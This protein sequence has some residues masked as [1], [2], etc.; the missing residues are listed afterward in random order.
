MLDFTL[1]E[2][3]AGTLFREGDAAEEAGETARALRCFEEGAALGDAICWSR[4][5]L[6][7]D[8]GK[9]VQIDKARAMRCYRMAWRQRDTVA[10]L[11]IA[12]LYRERGDRRAMFRWYRRAAR[13]DDG[14][15]EFELAKCYMTGTGV[16]RSMDM[17]IRSLAV[18]L[19]SDR[20]SE[21]EREEAQSL[22]ARFRPT[23]V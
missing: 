14:S 17:A 8:I 20:I 13:E 9:G 21:A 15:A 23:M 3:Q 10:A 1:T 5:G 11:N 19:N 6:M 18:A 4:L 7:F 22:Y 2:R 12:I 16:R